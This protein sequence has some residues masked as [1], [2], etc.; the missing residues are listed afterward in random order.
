[1]VDMKDLSASITMKGLVQKYVAVDA[2]YSE[3]NTLL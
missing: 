1:M 2:K 3:R